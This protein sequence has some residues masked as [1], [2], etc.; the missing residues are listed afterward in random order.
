MPVAWTRTAL[1][2]RIRPRWMALPDGSRY[3]TAQGSGTAGFLRQI[4]ANGS[5]LWSPRSHLMPYFDDAAVID[6]LHE[7]LLRTGETAREIQLVRHGQIRSPAVP[8][9][10][11]PC[12]VHWLLET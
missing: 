7:D 10:P 11:T 3:A 2:A 6:G 4:D 12:N 9:D 5:N 8:P 1:L